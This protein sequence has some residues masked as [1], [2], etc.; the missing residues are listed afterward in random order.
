MYKRKEELDSMK[1]F[2]N[3]NK[4]KCL[5]EPKVDIIFQTYL[6]WCDEKEL[7][8]IN[9]YIFRAYI[10]RHGYKNG[11]LTIANTFTNI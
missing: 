6:N 11:N 1:Q 3:D 10:R 4:I 2:W 7:S 5:S 9:K 8:P